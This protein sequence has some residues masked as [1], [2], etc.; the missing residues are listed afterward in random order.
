[1]AFESKDW[2]LLPDHILVEI[3][4]YLG[5]SDQVR[6]ARACKTWND[7]F[8]SP[9]LWTYFNFF[10][11]MPA[12]EKFVKCLEN[13]GKFLRHVYIELDQSVESNRQNA[14]KVIEGLARLKERRLKHITIKF[15]AE[16]PFF[17]SGKE[18]MDAL[19]LLFGP[20]SENTKIIHTLIEVDLKQ[21]AILFDDKFINVLSGNNPDLQTLNIQNTVLVC[22][23]TPEC[24][25]RLVQKC[26]KLKDIRIYNCSISEDILLALTEEDRVPLE[27]LSIICRREE[28]YSK[29]I[30]CEV[31]SAVVKK[32]PKLRV[33]LGFDHTVPLHKVSLVMKPE[34]PVSVLRLETFTYIYNEVRQA[35]SNYSKT[36]EKLV[37]QTPL[38]RNSPELNKALIELASECKILKCMHVFCVLDEK[39]VNKILELCPK[40]KA[41][42]CYTLKFKDEA[43]PWVAGNDLM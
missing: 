41:S 12:Q 23:V 40:M 43:S 2:S 11:Y 42:N 14:C 36:L 24:I 33:S 31:W 3:F 17:Y 19:S 15:T 32:L 8:H 35:S 21:L 16:N 1:M 26:R 5:R 37:L 25:L 7:N 9:Y 30:V 13:F 38:S 10:F 28:K 18:F 27:H 22:K 4:S 29:D 6:A 20:P 34:I 39:T